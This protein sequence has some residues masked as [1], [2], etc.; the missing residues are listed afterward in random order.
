MHSENCAAGQR[1]GGGRGRH[2]LEAA[3][4]SCSGHLVVALIEICHN[5]IVPK[6]RVQIRI[7]ELGVASANEG[8]VENIH[9][10]PAGHKRCRP[11][12]HIAAPTRPFVRWRALPPA[13]GLLNLGSRRRLNLEAR[14]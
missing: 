14:R 11:A 3:A 1:C 10:D 9:V 6:I 8:S 7:V 4:H 13:A 12:Q 5:L 2:A